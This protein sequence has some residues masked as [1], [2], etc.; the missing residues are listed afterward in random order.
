MDDYKAAAYNVRKV[1]KDAKREYGEKMESKFQEG[2]LR[3]GGFVNP[4]PGHRG[5]ESQTETVPSQEAEEI[6]SIQ[7]SPAELLPT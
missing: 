7:T 2:D 6:Q 3:S 1:V 5:K 4:A